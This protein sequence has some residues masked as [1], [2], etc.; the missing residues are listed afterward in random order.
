MVHESIQSRL[1][2]IFPLLE[3]QCYSAVVITTGALT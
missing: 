3:L 2:A 1:L